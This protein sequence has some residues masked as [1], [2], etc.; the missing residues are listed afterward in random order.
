MS[1]WAFVGILAILGVMFG[2]LY[3][4]KLADRQ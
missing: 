4:S 2:A 3:L 1:F